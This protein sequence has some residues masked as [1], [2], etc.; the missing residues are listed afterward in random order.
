MN[1]KLQEKDA[2]A[3]F[4]ALDEIVNFDLYKDN[5]FNQN[6]RES[7][8]DIYKQVKKYNPYHLKDNPRYVGKKWNLKKLEKKESV[9]HVNLSSIREI[10]MVKK[11]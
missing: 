9:I 6:E 7:I 2:S 5:L 1:L 4:L 3:L 11:A 10:Y 8:L